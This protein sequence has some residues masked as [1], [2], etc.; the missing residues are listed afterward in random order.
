M[1]RRLLVVCVVL[2]ASAGPVAGA[3][4]RPIDPDWSPPRTVYIPET[5]QTIDRLFLDLW[6][7]NGGA[8]SYGYPI[9]PEI[10]L[11]DGRIV[12][13]YGYARFE[14]WP[15]GD[16]NGNFV[17][18]GSIGTELRPP[19][20]P[21]RMNAV[22]DRAAREAARDAIAVERAW[23]TISPRK[24]ELLVEAEPS[25]RFVPETGHGVWG[26]FRQFWEGSGEAAYLGNPLT[27]EYVLAGISYQTFE[28]GQLTWRDGEAVRMTPVG[29]LLAQRYALD[30][31]PVPQGDVPAF[32]DALFVPPIAVPEPSEAPLPPVAVGRSM[33]VS[34]SEQ[35]MWAYE[36][37]RIVESTYVSTGKDRFE[38]PPGLFFVNTK[39]PV[40]DMAGVLG[41]ESYDVPSVPD[42]MYF[43]D[44]GH[45]IHGA[46][47]HDNF[48]Q[49]MSHG[50]INLPLD[51][52]AWL[53]GWSPIGMPVLI[54]P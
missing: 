16:A 4:A 32:S 27:E 5:G 12:Q 6:Y 49:R 15:Q 42:V 50:C 10:E 36:G 18:L 24:A 3:L 8:W 40:Q 47:W 28:R 54:V 48:G 20:V 7:G 39:V 13:Y 34:L 23:A 29:E 1:L 2:M 19:V 25:Y 30:R 11:D 22:Q 46:Y 52:S 45:A 35:A 9:T 43:T 41:G 53:Y 33:V 21:R 51:V 14:Y 17:T 38:T 44:R 31:D 26:G 37:T